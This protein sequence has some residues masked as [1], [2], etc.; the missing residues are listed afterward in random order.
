M[1]AFGLSIDEWKAKQISAASKQEIARN[2]LDHL[3]EVKKSAGVEWIYL[4]SDAEITNQV[5]LLPDT[6]ISDLPL[7]GV[8]FA[9]KD[10]IDVQGIPTTAA[11]P[12]FSYTPSDDAV[13]VSQLKKAGA[14]VL[15]KT[16][17]DQFA[18]GLVGT[19]SPYGVCS[20]VF[21][22]EH[23]SGGSSSGSAVSVANGA[24][25]FSLGTDT[26]GSG[27]VPAALNNL[28]GVKPTVGVWSAAGV[29]P[30]CKSL[31]TVSI[32]AQGTRDA[33][34]VFKVGVYYDELN[35][36][37]R[38]MPERPLVKFGK[39][40][41]VGVP[42]KAEFFGDK[43]NEALFKRYIEN[44]SE[45]GYEIRKIDCTDLFRLAKLLYE[46][47][48]VAERRW[49]VD[50]HIKEHGT[51]DMDPT[52]LKI[53]MGG[54]KVTGL[55]CFDK[56]YQRKEI[57]KAAHALMNSV[58]AI[59]MPTCPLNP[60]IKDV[61]AEPIAVNSQQGY[62]TNFVNL[63]DFAA[64]AIP[65]GWRPDGLPV[66][67]TFLGP[68]FSDYALLD[69][70]SRVLPKERKIGGLDKVSSGEDQIDIKSLP[71]PRTLPLAVVGAHLT[72]MPLNWQ[73]RKA[74]A[75]LSSRTF[76][77]PDYKL[78]ALQTTPPKPGI[79]RVTEGGRKIAI[80]VWDIPYETF[81]EFVAN[82]PAPLGIGQLE[83]ESGQWIS[84]FSWDGSGENKEITE[85]GGWRNFIAKTAKPG[86]KPFNK[87]LVANRGEIAVRIMRTLHKLGIASVAVYSEPD[88]DAEHVRIANQAINLHGH[89][90]AETY[91]SIRKILDAA[92]ATGSEAIIPGYG[93][94]S[95]NSDFADLCDAE[96]FI[97][98]GPSGEAMRQLGLKHSAR[99]IAKNANVPLVPG[100]QLL[101]TVEEAL[102]SVPA[103][104][105]YPIMLKST[106]GGGGIG[107]QRVDSDEELKTAYVTVRHQGEVY[108]GD[109][110]VFMESFVDNARHVEV[111][112]F[113]D[114]RGNAVALGERDCSLQRRNQ[115]VIEET[116]APLIPKATL[117][118]LHKSGADLAASM[119]YK[120]AGT[121]E[122]IYDGARDKFYFLEVNAR[123]QVEHPITEMVTG[124]DLVEWMLLVAADRPP[125]DSNTKSIP[126]KGAAMEARLYAENP[127]KDFRPS[128]GQL[129]ELS[130][131]EWARVDGWAHKGT[132]I[133]SEYDPTI[134][135]IIV[136]GEDREDALS[137]LQ[138]ALAETVVGGVVSNLDYLSSIAGSKMFHEAKMFTKVLDSYEYHPHAFEIVAPGGGTTVQ[139]WPG[140]TELWHIGVPPSGP[141]DSFSHRV[142]NE[143]VGNKEDVAA[144][145]L[146]LSG[147]TILFHSDA[148]VAVTGGDTTVLV[149][150]ESKPQWEAFEVKAGNKLVIGKITS[151]SRGYVAIRGG[152][153]TPKYLG[154]R[155]TFAQGSLGGH[156]GRALKVGD[157]VPVGDEVKTGSKPEVGNALQENL[158]PK[159]TNHWD[160]AVTVGPHG[161]PDFFAPEFVDEFFASDWKVHYNSNRFG[162]RLTGPK[163]KWARKDGGEGGLHPSNAHDYVYSLGAVNFTGNEP[164]ILTCDGPSLGGFVCLVVI[165]EAE[166]WKIGQVKP[167]DS[168]RFYPISTEQAGELRSAVDSRVAG[169]NVPLP[170]TLPT[171]TQPVLFKQEQPCTVVY[172]QAGDR[173]ILV[174]YGENQMDLSLRY[175]VHQ[176][177]EKVLGKVNGVIEMS[178]GVRS[179]HIEYE[180]RVI[181][182]KELLK[183]L[184]DIEKN[185][186][187][188]DPNWTVKSRIMHL[189]MVFEDSLTLSAVSR[190]AETIR[191]EAPWLP[192]NVDFITDVNALKDRREVRD[193]IYTASFMVMG[194]GDVYLGA[195]CAVPLDPRHRFLG[196]KYN[197]SR[198]WT[199]NGT[200]GL[201]GMYMC[202]Y[203]MESPGG[204]QLIGRTVPIWDK[205]C[206]NDYTQGGEP[207]LLRPFDQVRYYPVSE[208]ELEVLVS[209]VQKGTFHPRIEETVFSNA[210]YSEFLADNAESIEKHNA[211]I[212]Q[213]VGKFN[214]IISASDLEAVVTGPPPTDMSQF[215]DNAI[216][217][218]A[219]ITGRF[220]KSLIEE[221]NV[222]KP[223]DPLVV[224]EAMKT[225]MTVSAPDNASGKVVKVVHKNGDMVEAGDLMVVIEP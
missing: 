57:Q 221:G 80:E 7:F 134:A 130:F 210:E 166:L 174:E 45:S 149:D 184:T 148:L 20:S 121:I 175:R 15:G 116:P 97:F 155:S 202:I 180:P 71:A 50:S 124:L 192:N 185:E 81:G 53:V 55:D 207:W 52:V 49:A 209:E 86:R 176:L 153:N 218:Y 51:D 75:T 40:P 88:K 123:L 91:L 127:A 154:S 129:T 165:V 164:V 99:N 147:P 69:L 170:I 43:E 1:T 115:K 206:L 151:G 219:E 161:A 96:G 104:G 72:G 133:S 12:S 103:V 204:Y 122:F 68:A 87:V 32:F 73:L 109:S 17:M 199:P 67:V 156:N 194:L 105:G 22:T 200:V 217:V 158:I 198:S 11:C 58:D 30:A 54:D 90:A 19:R 223:G 82:I 216:M 98:V 141:M 83:L 128:P 78:F 76:T 79:K 33:E 10:N 152:I 159:F 23:V 162:V 6:D 106:A 26:A 36:Y 42:T 28:I 100:T 37:S 38:P 4:L 27:R 168:I 183:V 169:H 24:V 197:P 60:R 222:V 190:Y 173:F 5:D 62:Y 8:P 137:K 191:S 131:P 85:Y 31:D 178:P 213:Q 215:S 139:D 135:K 138:K 92:A 84:G 225:E 201:G 189:P 66:G 163:P 193:M 114:G 150:G 203:T 3:T 65:N 18:T 140:R 132:V 117:D 94:L 74:K 101:E 63:A 182:Q 56:E 196:S 214:E 112:V 41:V 177:E 144:L 34:I 77:S 145:E 93:F 195:P 14:I 39:R 211:H 205:L 46:G 171:P 208:Q 29:V 89:T 118:H 21:S 70:A 142:A 44:L 47:P 186:L 157:L 126:T 59:L 212:S 136:Y 107:L 2:I 143:L 102:A 48:W 9:V 160:V 95:E 188:S 113:G 13:V 25:P 111:Q 61:Q 146:T 224:V 125:F 108:F 119:N 120:C 64:L 181:S 167:G 172:R 35:A 110:G 187:H 220:W 16:N 179:V